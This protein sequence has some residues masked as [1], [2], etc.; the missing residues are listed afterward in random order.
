M[1]GRKK[2]S[3]WTLAVSLGV[4]GVAPAYGR[5]RVE[6]MCDCGDWVSARR[7][8]Q[9]IALEHYVMGMLNGDGIG[10]KY[11]IFGNPREFGSGAAYL[12][13]DNY[14]QYH[15]L[16]A[17]VTGVLPLSRKIRLEAKE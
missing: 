17:I 10:I 13:I 5:V 9:A 8:N 15:P 4:I 1:T 7:T 14:C 16:D 11:K 3:C 2:V 12:W 6:G